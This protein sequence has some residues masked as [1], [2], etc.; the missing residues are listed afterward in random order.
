MEELIQKLL[1]LEKIKTDAYT[2]DFATCEVSEIVSSIIT[3]FKPIFSE[4]FTINMSN[5]SIR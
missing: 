2:M 1:H 5:S 3:D 4:K